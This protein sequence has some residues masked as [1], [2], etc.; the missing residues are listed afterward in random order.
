MNQIFTQVIMLTINLV[1]KNVFASQMG[2]KYFTRER[3]FQETVYLKQQINQTL[4]T[5][6]VLQIPAVGGGCRSNMTVFYQNK[7]WF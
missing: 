6:N 3:L 2:I 5:H 7:G 4:E 1:L